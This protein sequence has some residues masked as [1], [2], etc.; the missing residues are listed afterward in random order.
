M[1][2]LD[3]AKAAIT[4]PFTR[5]LPD[6]FYSLIGQIMV[7]WAHLE[8]RLQEVVFLAMGVDARKGRLGVK[9]S[10]AAEMVRLALDL[11][12]VDGIVINVGSLNGLAEV[13]NRRNLLAHGVWFA[14]RD[15]VFLRDLTGTWN[16]SSGAP[17]I[18]RKVLPAG[19]PMKADSLKN[20]LDSVQQAIADT[21]SLARAIQERRSSSK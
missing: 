1:T 18:K 6:E 16:S 9:S 11:A 4:L 20:L 14:D 19:I 5:T 21:E 17:G 8:M 12:A 2:Q 13:E 10:R 3:P 7:E 15:G